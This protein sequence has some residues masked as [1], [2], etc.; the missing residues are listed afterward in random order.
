MLTEK[1]NKLLLKQ[2]VV[3]VAS[4]DSNGRPTAAPKFVV[5]IER[6]CIYL[7]DYV[8]GKT[9]DNF[10]KNPLVSLSFFDEE[11]L[12][13]YLLNGTVV[14][15]TS[16]PEFDVWMK[17]AQK[18]EIDLTIERVIK[19]IQKGKKHANFD[20]VSPEHRVIFKV[21]VNE[22]VEISSG[23]KLRRENYK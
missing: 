11:D 6:N 22:V 13:G 1:I 8:I 19:G 7:V 16:G 12:T 2:K 4:A 9:F 18:K 21:N 14:I 15:L 17:E 10:S 5:A 20:F 3:T 23:G